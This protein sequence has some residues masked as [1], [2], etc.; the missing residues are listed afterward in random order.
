MYKKVNLVV[1][2][3]KRSSNIQSIRY[4]SSAPVESVQNNTEIS[5][6]ITEIAT[7]INRMKSY[8][9]H[10][11]GALD[12]LQLSQTSRKPFIQSPNQVLVKIT[13]SSVNPL[14]VAMIGKFLSFLILD[15]SVFLIFLL[16]RWLWINSF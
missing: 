12:E 10:N 1:R 3:I 2:V 9:I 14:D 13:A 8:Q 4:F 5:Q 7:L 16:F 11:Y 6:N 15:F